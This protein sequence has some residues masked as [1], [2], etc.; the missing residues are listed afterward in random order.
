[1]LVLGRKVGGSIVIDHSLDVTVCAIRKNHVVVSIHEHGSDHFRH[2]K[3]FLADN[4]DVGHS[5]AVRL[6]G[7]KGNQVRLGIIAPREINVAR[8][9]IYVK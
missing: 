2:E 9:E 5:A 3:I 8:D 4:V 6:T 1:M 7:I